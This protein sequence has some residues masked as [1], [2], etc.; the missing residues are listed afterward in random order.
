[1]YE[2]LKRLKDLDQERTRLKK[3]DPEQ[4]SVAE[5]KPIRE[6]DVGFGQLLTD[7]LRELR[8]KDERLKA[9][10][11]KSQNEY[12]KE[13]RDTARTLKKELEVLKRKNFFASYV[14]MQLR[15]LAPIVSQEKSKFE[16]ERKRIVE[17]NNQS[18]RTSKARRM[19]KTLA[20]AVESEWNSSKTNEFVEKLDRIRSLLDSEVMLNIQK[21]VLDIHANT[22]GT[23]KLLGQMSS[24]WLHD[25]AVSSQAMRENKHAVESVLEGFSHM[26]DAARHR[27][28]AVI[29]TINSFIQVLRSQYLFP[30]LPQVLTA[31][32]PSLKSAAL[33][34]YETVENA[35]LAALYFPMKEDRE[36]QV[37]GAHDKTCAWIFEEPSRYSKPWTNFKRWLEEEN[38]C[39]WIEGKAGCGKSTLM[40]FLVSDERTHLSL[41]A[42]AQPHDS[43]TASC[44]FWMAGSPLQ[45]NEEGLLRCLLHTILTQRRGLISKVFPGRYNT[46]TSMYVLEPKL[47]AVAT[48]LTS[49]NRPGCTRTIRIPTYSF[50]ATWLDATNHFS[51]QVNWK[52]TVHPGMCWKAFF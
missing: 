50:R 2:Q 3:R 46:M 25:G 33:Y 6:L 37:R 31:T 14:D 32:D 22:Q 47:T 35:I 51:A 45:K 1:M 8:Q 13:E 20:K 28:E 40:K 12:N 52:R 19:I 43:V 41:S 24:T 18:V 16:N 36:F 10:K 30:T 15:N 9:L 27:H 11:R 17:A 7:E 21:S 38:G 42:W 48:T 44:F 34:G 4:R 5:Q 29:K 23:H 49:S 39:Y 26:E